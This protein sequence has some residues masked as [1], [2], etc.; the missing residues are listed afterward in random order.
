MKNPIARLFEANDFA[1]QVYA[2]DGSPWF[3]AKD[4][5]ECIETKNVGQALTRLDDDEKDVII[6]NDVIGR[7]QEMVIISESG[8]FSL[9]LSSRKP[10]AKKFKKWVTSEV[11][12]AIKNSG[13]YLLGATD[14]ERMENAKKAIIW[15]R[16]REEAKKE[17]TAMTDAIK[18]QSELSGAIAVADDYAREADMLNMVIIGMKSAAWKRK[19]GLE[20]NA[21]IRDSMEDTRLTQYKKLEQYNA[22][23]ISS[24]L[25]FETREGILKSY[26]AINLKA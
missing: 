20:K 23:L 8:L 12:P 5:C 11:L 4:V 6:L 19:L 21:A 16:E 7:P 14:A 15:Q 26:F 25:P 9:V 22:M 17:Y 18:S 24:G 2:K 10:A 1:V 13:G 3:L